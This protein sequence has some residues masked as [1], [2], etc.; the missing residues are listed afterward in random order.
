MA[1]ASRKPRRSKA[2]DLIIDSYQKV[3]HS[4]AGEVVLKDLRDAF[5]RQPYGRSRRETDFRCGQY[6]VVDRILALLKEGENG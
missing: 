1:A 2:E 3:F 6:E 5:Y 4:P